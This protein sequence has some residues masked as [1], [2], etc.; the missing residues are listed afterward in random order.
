MGNRMRSGVV[1]LCGALALGGCV[2]QNFF[3]KN[4]VTYDRYERD[5]VGCSTAAAQKVPTNTQVGWMPYVGIQESNPVT[6]S[7]PTCAI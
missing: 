1:I 4:A 3:V 2:D 5:Y 6:P 7:K